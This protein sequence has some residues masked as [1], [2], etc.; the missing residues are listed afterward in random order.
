MP[1]AKGR[2]GGARSRSGALPNQITIKNI[3]AGKGIRTDTIRT[4][5]IEVCRCDS[6]G[7]I[8]YA[9]YTERTEM[10]EVEFRKDRD[11]VVLQHRR[12]C[13]IR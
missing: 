9:P 5:K 10:N 3:F 7:A 12:G 11:G 6:C 1:G 4:A 8:G 13:K 2:S